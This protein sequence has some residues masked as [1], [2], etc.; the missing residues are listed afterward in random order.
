MKNDI[1][2]RRAF[3][4]SGFLFAETATGFSFSS[5]AGHNIEYL[6]KLVFQLGLSEQSEDIFASRMFYP[7]ELKVDEGKWLTAIEQLHTGTEGGSSHDLEQ[8]DTFMGGIV[9]WV[10]KAGMPTS[11]SCDG[12][13]RNI[14]E[15]VFLSRTD[16][17]LFDYFLR[18]SGIRVRYAAP[19]L[20]TV[21]QFPQSDLGFPLSD[22]RYWLLDV[23]EQI[24]SKL[25]VLQ[26]FVQAGHRLAPP[27]AQAAGR[28]AK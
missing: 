23:A 21:R 4:R 10:G 20:L 5:E 9:R 14:A 27:R 18:W 7:P 13:N 26:E 19:Q 22:S 17:I 25:S 6:R 2:W 12:H 24:H 16:G 3:V 8:M 15:L 28:L 11:Y 1:E